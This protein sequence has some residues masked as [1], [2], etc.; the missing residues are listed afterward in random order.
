M[1]FRWE[2]EDKERRRDIFCQSGSLDQKQAELNA[3]IQA[4]ASQQ[5]VRVGGA[6]DLEPEQDPH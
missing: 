3:A 1:I 4:V 2:E 6:L 5:G